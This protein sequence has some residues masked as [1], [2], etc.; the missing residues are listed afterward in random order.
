MTKEPALTDE[1]IAQIKTMTATMSVKEIAFKF[2]KNPSTIYKVISNHNII[3]EDRR[4]IITRPNNSK[5]KVKRTPE[6][7]TSTFNRYSGIPDMW[8]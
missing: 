4:K 6:K 7:H 2:K 8:I 5:P 3:R 1:Q